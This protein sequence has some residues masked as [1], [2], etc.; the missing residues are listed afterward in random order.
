M[1]TAKPLVFVSIPEKLS[2]IITNVVTEL[3]LGGDTTPADRL[4]ASLC[5]PCQ[6]LRFGDFQSN[7]AMT[8]AKELKR[9]L[10]K[11]AMSS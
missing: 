8:L 3:L 5:T 2:A 4:P 9:N 1:N 6:D 7:V 11:T 10:N